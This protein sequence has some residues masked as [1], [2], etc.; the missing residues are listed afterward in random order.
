MYKSCSILNLRLVSFRKQNR[1]KTPN[2]K[3]RSIYCSFSQ[4]LL[5][6]T[7]RSTFLHRE[8][9][10]SSKRRVEGRSSRSEKRNSRRTVVP[11]SAFTLQNWYRCKS[12][13]GTESGAVR[14]FSLFRNTMPIHQT[15]ANLELTQQQLR[16]RSTAIK[17]RRKPPQKL[18]K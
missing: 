9:A 6:I 4:V 8:H 14:V 15:K 2:N 18:Q 10:R 17:V 1:R 16:P 3:C 7:R 11:D 12:T 5:T 13:S